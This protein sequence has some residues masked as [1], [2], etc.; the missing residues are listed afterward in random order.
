MS[1]KIQKTWPAASVKLVPITELQQYAGN[2]RVHG[3][4]QVD[5]LAKAIRRFGFVM[6]LLADEKGV[7][8]AGHGRLLAAQ[9]LGHEQVP[10]ATARGWTDEEKRAYCIA[11]N[12]LAEMSM[13]D[14]QLLGEE[15]ERLASGDYLMDL[16]YSELE[17]DLILAASS[18]DAVASFKGTKD[19]STQGGA[20]PVACRIGKEH[21]KLGGSE[22]EDLMAAH[23]LYV[24]E[25]GT[26]DGFFTWLCAERLAEMKAESGKPVEG[27]IASK[28]E[29]AAA[30]VSE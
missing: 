27:V 22:Y 30:A 20:V 7:L 25:H 12:R 8:I 3:E 1:E 4:E 16:G 6:P 9:L 26:A 21:I 19:Q 23:H 10:V 17:I 18:E 13:W 2:A 29:P 15:V 11:D 5:L 24:S 28:R 14:E